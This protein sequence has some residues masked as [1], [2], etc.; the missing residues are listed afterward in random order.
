ML[1][2]IKMNYGEN[3]S[4]R[5][6]CAPE[7]FME[8]KIAPSILAADFS[9]LG[10]QIKKAEDGGAKLLHL[11][12]MDGRFVPNFTFGAVVIKPLRKVCS[13]K[14]DCHLMVERPWDFIDPCRA[15]GADNITVH[16]ESLGENT[17]EA[18]RYIKS[19]GLSAGLSI[20]PDTPVSA[21]EPYKNDAD[22]ILIMSVYPGFGGQKFIEKSLDRI[23]ETRKIV[24]DGKDIEVD[25]G[26][27]MDNIRTI[28]DAGANVI[29]AGSAVFG[30]DDIK[31]AILKLRRAAGDD[32]D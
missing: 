13:L 7:V 1:K 17:S 11:D 10:E 18:L 28:V 30:S 25:G 27:Y 22:M 32:A 31:E 23:K 12:I 2:L 19:L 4:S 26:I 15:A 24:G 5:K 6:A 21:I 3:G 29:V 14:F 20:S 8:I 9:R 16:Y